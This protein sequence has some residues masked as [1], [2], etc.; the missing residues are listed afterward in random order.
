MELHWRVRLK[1]ARY[2]SE[3]EPTL[4]SPVIMKPSRDVEAVW[5]PTS[6][7][8]VPHEIILN[9]LGIFDV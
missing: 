4:F 2:M 3:S 5:A 7:P 8:V 9:A 1:A 6:S